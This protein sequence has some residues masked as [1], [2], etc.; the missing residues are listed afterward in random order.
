MNE[1]VAQAPGSSAAVPL[2]WDASW[3][4]WQE[5][6]DGIKRYVLVVSR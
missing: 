1:V 2:D 3:L 4:G 5:V 6:S